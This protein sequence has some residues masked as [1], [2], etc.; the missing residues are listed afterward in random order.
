MRMAGAGASM[1]SATGADWLIDGEE[2]VFLAHHY[3]IDDVLEKGPICTIYRATNRMTSKTF[4]VKSIDVQKY[5]ACGF[6]ME[7]ID[8]E[9]TICASLRH[10]YFMQLKD[11]ITGNNAV[12]M[13]FEYV[14]GSDICFE[15][16]K[17]AAADI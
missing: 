5:K 10:H 4:T 2:S 13:I 17:R 6:S 9:I 7:D 16:V 12:H 1:G 3:H 11:A 15:I 8:R 14:E